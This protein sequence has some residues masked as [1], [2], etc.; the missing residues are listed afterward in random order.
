MAPPYVQ[1]IHLAVL[2]SYL[3]L[4]LKT[5]KKA[6]KHAEGGADVVYGQERAMAMTASRLPDKAGRNAAQR[7]D[8]LPHLPPTQPLA[9][10]VAVFDF[11][12]G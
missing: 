2:E 1:R 3:P 9:P 10:L 5:K 6:P 12:T 4:P 11:R 7:P 8:G